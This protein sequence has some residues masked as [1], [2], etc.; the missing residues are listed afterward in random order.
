MFQASRS[1]SE[2]MFVVI[3]FGFGLAVEA[4]VETAIG[5][6]IGVEH[7]DGEFGSVEPDGFTDLFEDEF[8]VGFVFRGGEA[9]GSAGDFDGVGVEDSL[10]PEVFG[11]AEL[12][13]IIEAPDN[14][15]V[16]MVFRAR[17][18][19]VIDLFHLFLSERGLVWV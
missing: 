18:V 16:A 14:G 1:F 17:G 12:K 15:G 5:A 19:V 7:E 9:F 4:S 6:A 13:A 3:R 10:A 2:F 11:E 8:A